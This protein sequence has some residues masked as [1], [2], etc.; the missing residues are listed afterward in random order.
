M[1]R[2]DYIN[3]L[4]K[5]LLSDV[6]IRL[7]AK[8][9]GQF[10]AIS[11]LSGS[12]T[13]AYVFMLKASQ[14]KRVADPPFDLIKRVAGI[15]LE[16]SLHW[17]SEKSMII[18]AYNI[19]EKEFSGVPLPIGVFDSNSVFP[20]L[21]VLKGCLCLFSNVINSVSELYVMKEYGVVG[22]WT[23]LSVVLSDVSHVAS[24]N[25]RDDSSGFPEHGDSVLLVSNAKF[26][27]LYD[28]EVLGLPNDFRVGMTFVESLVSPEKDGNKKTTETIPRPRQCRYDDMSGWL[29]AW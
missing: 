11:S 14:W 3:L 23:K 17:L 10:V 15:F 6:F 26:S 24:L 9:L 25:F 20:R 4:P 29:K 8:S 7:P 12:A 16:G 19:A 28:T 21:G 5:E 18:W 1:G 13:V 27:D 2:R 22:S